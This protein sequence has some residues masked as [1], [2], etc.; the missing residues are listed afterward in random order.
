MLISIVIDNYNY[1]KFL[2]QAIDSALAQSY[3]PH[4]VIVV[5]DGSTDESRSTI[6]KYGDRVRAVFKENGGQASALNFGFH[7]EVVIFLDSD[8]WLLPNALELVAEA[9]SDERLSKV[10]WPLSMADESGRPTGELQPSGAL[11]SGELSQ[12]ILEGGPTSSLSSPTSGNAWARWFLEKVMPIPESTDYY[13]KCADEYL[14]T[15]APVFGLIGKI[16]TPLGFYRVYGRNIY[17]SLGYEEKLQYEIAGHDQQ[18]AA[19]KKTLERD[20]Y[21]IDLESWKK[22]S[23]F[24]RLDRALQI[25]ESCGAA[26]KR[27]LLA[28]E[29]RWG[30]AGDFRG[31]IFLPFPSQNGKYW[32]PPS[33]DDEAIAAFQ[34]QIESADYFAVGWPAAWWLDE[35]PGFFLTSG[36]D[37]P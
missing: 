36:K 33:N 2:V 6:N 8:D 18:C 5:D 25:L 27:V 7:G 23:W 35:Y 4:E 30:V 28:D 14:Y 9:F 37:S 34:S 21:T 12:S 24:Y 20:G 29:A 26:G 17:S 10:H 13:K 15:L 22:N 11:P 1:D 19:L 16:D 32:G 31:I 3:R